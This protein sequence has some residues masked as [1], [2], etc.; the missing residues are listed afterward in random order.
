MKDNRVLSH[1]PNEILSMIFNY[2]L[3]SSTRDCP[4]DEAK[5]VHDSLIP[6]CRLFRALFLPRR[7]RHLVIRS[8][9]PRHVDFIRGIKD[10]PF[11]V[12]TLRTYV[13]KLTFQDWRTSPHVDE[14]N[15]WVASALLTRYIPALSCFPN[16]YELHLTDMSITR[17]F[18]DAV[19]YLGALSR[20]SISRCA[21]GAF[22]GA[23]D[24]YPVEPPST[25]WTSF[26]FHDNTCSMEYIYAF[27]SLISS[28]HLQTLNTT[29]W[30]LIHALAEHEEVLLEGLHE[31]ATQIPCT[32]ATA[33][34]DFLIRTPSVQTLRITSIQTFEVSLFDYTATYNTARQL[35]DL[36]PS[37]LPNLTCV[38][39][40]AML[41]DALVR[42]RPVSSIDVTSIIYS[43]GTVISE[44][45]HE[46]VRRQD[47][48][49]LM[50]SATV[51]VRHLTI[52]MMMFN[53][54]VHDRRLSDVQGLESL[55]IY[56]VSATYDAE[57][58]TLKADDELPE[59]LSTTVE[60]ITIVNRGI[61]TKYDFDR[62]QCFLGE[63]VRLCRWFSRAFPSVH[64]ISFCS[65]I[66]WH[67]D[68]DDQEWWPDIAKSKKVAR[69]FEEVRDKIPLGRHAAQMSLH[70]IFPGQL[71]GDWRNLVQAYEYEGVTSVHRGPRDGSEGVVSHEEL[72]RALRWA[73]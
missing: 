45:D 37:A 53:V 10:Y 2:L 54:L 72:Q 62:V 46:T 52:G 14:G 23:E 48:T 56:V 60:R 22:E 73:L 20:V 29:Q 31:L 15:E 69:A 43:S 9:A 59:A 3:P 65:D 19:A 70:A 40:S 50:A 17:S 38:Q 16:L 39:C 18:F 68:P 57:H 11:P 66:T 49:A 30:T 61:T 67:L 35:V 51:P 44:S 58:D 7:L 33:L 27:V 63:Q 12:H 64:Q 24:P 32:P 28:P 47:F 36:P 5:A 34:K 21:F 25:P 13:E 42:G 71:Y 8:S 41:L 55:T 4:E 6:V 1:L 26:A